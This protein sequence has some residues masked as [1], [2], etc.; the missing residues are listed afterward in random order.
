M[1]VD[2]DGVNGEPVGGVPLAQLDNRLLAAR[3]RAAILQAIFDG[4]FQ[5]KLPNED[6]L[7]EMLSV[8]RTTVRTALQD[9]ERDGVITRQRAIGTRINPHVRPST[10]TLQRMVGFDG[11]L[12]ERG[13]DVAVEL[14]SRWG[15]AGEELAAI[16]PLA[17][18]Q[19]CLVIEKSYTADGSLAL[20]ITDAI[21]RDGILNGDVSGAIDPSLFTFSQRRFRQPIHHAVVQLVP[22]VKRDGDTRLELAEGTPYLRLHETHYAMGGEPVAF[23]VIDFDDSFIQLEVVRTQ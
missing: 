13:H 3:A 21:P 22:R 15:P 17:A 20:V 5:S 1:A 7:A 11:L 6:R 19:E 9:L 10:L 16:F 4:R 23:S 18:D 12:S 2:E 8:S 14:T